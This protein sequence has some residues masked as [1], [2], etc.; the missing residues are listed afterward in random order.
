MLATVSS[1]ADQYHHTVNTLKYADRAKE[2]KTHV[3]ANVGTVES[4]V[5][6]YQRMID[7]LQVVISH[8]ICGT[9]LSYSVVKIDNFF[10]SGRASPRI[11]ASKYS[12]TIVGNICRTK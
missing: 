1:S 3:H 8:V 11:A 10:L 9:S 12:N 4:H 2:I 6:E 5:T 7:S